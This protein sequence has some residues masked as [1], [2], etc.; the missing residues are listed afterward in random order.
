MPRMETIEAVKEYHKENA[1]KNRK[2][3]SLMEERFGFEFFSD[4]N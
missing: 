2:I 4:G 1:V 3:G